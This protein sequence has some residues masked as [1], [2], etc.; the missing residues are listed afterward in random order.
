MKKTL[1]AAAIPALLIANAS[2]VELYDDG[3]NSFAIGGH[4]TLQTEIGGGDTEVTGNSPRINFSWNSD[5]GNGFK[6]D[7]RVEWGMT[8]VTGD[9]SDVLFNR[10]GYIGVGHDT[11]GRL[12]IGKQWSAYNNASGATDTSIVIS[13]D[14]LHT[15]DDHGNLGLGRA[16]E[17]I[18]YSNAFGLAGGKLDF[19]AQYQGTNSGDRDDDGNVVEGGKDYDDRYSFATGYAFGDTRIAYALSTGDVDY[20]AG[21]VKTQAQVVSAKW[22]NYGDGLHIA[23]AYSWAENVRGA[24][25]DSQGYE[26]VVAYGTGNLTYAVKHQ[27]LKQ[28]DQ[29]DGRTGMDGTAF[30]QSFATVEWNVAANFVPYAA[31]VVEHDLDIL[32]SD[33]NPID[34][35]NRFIL[36]A[37]IYF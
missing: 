5:L 20:G 34:N 14:A 15:Y 29:R 17:A 24:D 13:S 37:R 9:D 10:L 1:L 19:V 32:D 28:D 11:F 35:D 21:F 36:G 6:L 27:Y 4:M 30:N 23:G 26:A 2:A 22:G 3:K 16:N 18:Q 33:Q 12:S 7:S 8:D 25:I 31:Y